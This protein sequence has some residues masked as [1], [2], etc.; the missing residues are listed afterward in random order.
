MHLRAVDR[1]LAWHYW[2]SRFVAHADCLASAASCKSLLGTDERAM[3]CCPVD[4]M[5]TVVVCCSLFLHRKCYI[6]VGHDAQVSTVVQSQQQHEFWKLGVGLAAAAAATAAAP[7]Q[8]AH[9][10]PSIEK[11]IKLPVHMFT[12]RIEATLQ[13]VC[14]HDLRWINVLGCLA[15]SRMPMPKAKERIVAAPLLSAGLVH[16]WHL[17]AGLYDAVKDAAQ[18]RLC[19]GR[20]GLRQGHAGEHS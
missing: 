14:A 20:A 5:R 9:C 1:L 12:A 16:R 10:T 13:R 7:P 2:S 3:Y 4:A 17:T 19:A 6:K 11:P 15:W 18:H 8:S